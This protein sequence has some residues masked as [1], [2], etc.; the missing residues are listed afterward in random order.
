MYSREKVGVCGRTGCGKSTLMITIYRLI[1]PCGGTILIDGLDITT[2]GLRD[3]RSKLSLVPQVRS[4]WG[5]RA[6]SCL[7]VFAGAST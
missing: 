6:R 2:I 1:E 3:L 5:A 4:R 7:L